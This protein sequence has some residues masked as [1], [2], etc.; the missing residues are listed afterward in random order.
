[1]E[2]FIHFELLGK[3]WNKKKIQSIHVVREEIQSLLQS[4]YIEEFNHS[5]L[6]VIQ[7]KIEGLVLCNGRNLLFSL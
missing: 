4:T 3:T 5:W 7:M 6:Y 1:M 2:D